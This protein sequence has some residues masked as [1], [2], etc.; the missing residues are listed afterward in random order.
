MADVMPEYA[1]A[2]DTI[3]LAARQEAVKVVDDSGDTA[4]DGLYLAV[5]RLALAR[6]R[7]QLDEN[8][9]RARVHFSG[10]L[11]AHA[12]IARLDFAP[13]D[14]RAVL[15]PLWDSAVPARLEA[16]RHLDLIAEPGGLTDGVRK[17]LTV[18]GTGHQTAAAGQ[19]ARDV[20]RSGPDGYARAWY[21]VC[22]T[23]LLL[24]RRAARP[25][26]TSMVRA[27]A[28]KLYVARRGGLS[29]TTLD[30]WLAS[31]EN[32]PGRAGRRDDEVSRRHTPAPS[33]H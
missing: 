33:A 12:V 14:A 2:A 24:A 25:A 6:V 1:R 20:V 5:E 23:Y 15:A 32:Q 10:I 4:F 13:E 28:E 31:H 26:A 21:G 22:G 16:R 17:L 27:G 9:E 8:A 29:R 3:R 30:A 11:G 7:A 18:S 19:L